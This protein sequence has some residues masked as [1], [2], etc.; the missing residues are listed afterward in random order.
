MNKPMGKQRR[1]PLNYPDDGNA[2]SMMLEAMS[3]EELTD[4]L[5]D[6][7]ENMTERNY[8]S[9]LIDAYLAALDRKDP[10]PEIPDAETSYTN[11]QKRILRIFPERTSKKVASGNRFYRVW[12]IGLVA[13][14]TLICMLGSMMVAQA[15]GLDVFGTMG[16]WTD[17]IFSFGEIRSDG[18]VDV[19]NDTANAPSGSDSEATFT[20]LQVALDTYG[21]TEVSEPTWFPEGY[22]F[23]SVTVDCRTNGDLIGMAA[24]YSNGTYTLFVEFN[25]YRDEPSMQI[26]KTDVPVETFA[27]H[28]TTVY[29][30][31]NINNNAAAWMTEHFEC[32]IT[33]AVE[34]SELQQMVL[35]IYADL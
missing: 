5:N 14:L 31:E 3:V 7:L 4:A 11:F 1:T 18:A 19:P 25:N 34:K 23:K 35:S 28:D 16:R 9:A 33:G 2:F 26:E 12:R 24:E 29:L 30:L 8:D 15:A 13:V 32:C 20:S 17:D 27:V 21:I 10:M 22:R 6:L